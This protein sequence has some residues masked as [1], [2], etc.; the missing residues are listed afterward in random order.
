MGE[1]DP[2]KTARWRGWLLLAALLACAP[3]A[4][5]DLE[6]AR[7]PF[8]ADARE[9]VDGSLDAR[10]RDRAG[11]V[12]REDSRTPVWWRVRTTAPVSAQSE[13]QLLLA[14]PYLTRVE[15]WVPGVAAPIR[16]AIYGDD[17]DA[18]YASRAL[19]IALPHGLQPG[20]AVYL[21][22]T[23]PA[24]VPMMLSVRTRDEVHRA[25][26]AY[27]A[28]RTMILSSMVVLGL[29]ALA[30]WAGVGERSF[31]FLALMLACS[32][33]YIAAM[34][35]EA[36]NLPPLDALFGRSP[37]GAR[38][39]ACLGTM[40]SNIYMRMYLDLRS[41]APRID[42]MLW[43]LTA[44]MGVLAALN[45][46]ID[47]SVLALAGNVVLVLSALAI[48][49]AAAV[50]S[51]KGVRAARFVLVSW[52]PLIVFSILKAAQLVGLFDGAEWLSHALASSF[53]LAGLLL[54]IGLSDKLMQLRRDRDHASRQAST[55]P[56]TGTLSRAA[57]ERRLG[58]EIE[59]A[60]RTG[61]P[62]CVAFVDIDRFKAINDNHG[63]Y[64]GDACLRFIGQRIRN[65]LRTQDVLGRYGGDELLALMP[66][67]TLAEGL[68][69]CEQLRAAVNCRPLSVDGLL[70]RGSLSL[71]LAQLR[72]GEQAGQ[73]LARADAAL[74]ASKAAGRDR[75]SGDAAIAQQETNTSP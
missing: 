35:G 59:I 10:F 47:H 18:R 16:H 28:W 9:V 37:Q 7:L 69:R 60:H 63:H 57:I 38:V 22:V 53:A 30:F 34:G 19:V 64:V 29:L 20:E 48:F 67:T 49:A 4:A 11:A 13:P 74:Y 31:V 62:L 23:A 45:L 68:A 71:G 52:L 1:G 14:S 54:T 75:V 41:Q 17:T 56:L 12:V 21:R 44:A 6:V 46:A 50:A 36:R 42:R 66:D 27:V 32:A 51:A 15:A 26:L 61:R 65:R 25:D 24:A 43:W 72:P 33:L 3:V 70:V 40:A 2:G 5:Q 73:L 8:D 58:E 55:D 39:I